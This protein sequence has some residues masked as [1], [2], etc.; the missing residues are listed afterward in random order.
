[1]D[2]KNRLRLVKNEHAKAVTIW[3]QHYMLLTNSKLKPTEN[4]L[5]NYLEQNP[6]LKL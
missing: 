4:G 2:S 6:D 5:K 1:M 3:N